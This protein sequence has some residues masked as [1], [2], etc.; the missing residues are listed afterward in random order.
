MFRVMAHLDFI[1]ALKIAILYLRYKKIYYFW[2]QI[3][4]LFTN[5]HYLCIFKR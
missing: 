3:A 4:L 5:L 2:S 1:F